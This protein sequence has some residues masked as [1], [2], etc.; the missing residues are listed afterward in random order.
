VGLHLNHVGIVVDD[1]DAAIEFFIELGLALEGTAAV[2]DASVDRVIGLAGV[3][4]EIAMLV[5]PDGCG[6]VE[7]SRFHSPRPPAGDP[8]APSNAL[9]MRHLA[10][11]VDDLDAVLARLT[12]CGARL[13]GDVE[14]VGETYR[15]CYVRGPEGI[16]VEVAQRTR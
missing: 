5:T 1:L 15:L 6:R 13:L 4:S 7:L 16:I 3:R 2:D 9:G 10:F 11:E 14:R 12:A 8:E